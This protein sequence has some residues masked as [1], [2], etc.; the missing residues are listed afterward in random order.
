MAKTLLLVGGQPYSGKHALAAELTRLLG[1]AAPV[2]FEQTSRRAGASRRYAELT[3]L[4]RREL[5]HADLVVAVGPLTRRAH[6]RAVTSLLDKE[7]ARVIYVECTCSL[8]AMKRH[9]YSQYANAA[10][11]FLELRAARAAGLRAGY[12]NID[13]D[14]LPPGTQLVRVDGGETPARVAAEVVRACGLAAQ[15]AGARPGRSAR[16]EVLVIDDDADLLSTLTDVLELLGCDVTTASSSA[17][18]IALGDSSLA[19]DL[20]FLDYALPGMSGLDL[21]P[22]LRDRWPR[23]DVVMLSAYDEAW[24]CDEAFR[25]QVGEYLRKPV[26]VTDL[27]RVLDSVGAK[28]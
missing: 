6:R 21:A 24:L 4:A 2:R 14:E 23:A 3:A 16:L 22:V 5:R 25:E 19:P 9:I 11:A 8:A 27:L 18:A 15:P 1:V 28:H 26:S 10:P 20:V 13:A 7:G 12:R 17:E